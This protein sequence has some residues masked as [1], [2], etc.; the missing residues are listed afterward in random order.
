MTKELLDRAKVLCLEVDEARDRLN[1]AKNG[2]VQVEIRG[3]LRGV[4]TNRYI[5]K[6]LDEARMAHI[7]YE[8]ISG[9]QEQYDKLQAE[10]DALGNGG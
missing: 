7:R 5:N 3:S 10:F 8:V 4:R 6:N 1:I 2:E 9:L